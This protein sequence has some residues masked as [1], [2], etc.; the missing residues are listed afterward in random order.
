MQYLT[1]IQDFS[2]LVEAQV[3]GKY[4]PAT[5]HDPEEFPDVEITAVQYENEQLPEHF[6]PLLYDELRRIECEIQCGDLRPV[7]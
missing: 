3:V 6:F 2:V 1:K 4:Y 5:S 7:S